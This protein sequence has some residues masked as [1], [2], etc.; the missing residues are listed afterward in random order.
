MSSK[1]G[2]S[3][4]V[5]LSVALLSGCSVFSENVVRPPEPEPLPAGR[6]P[7][8]PLAKSMISVPISVDLSAMLHHANDESVVPKKFD[9]WGAH[10]KS[11]KGMDFKYYAERDDFAINPSGAV[12]ATS[13]EGE[14]SLRDWW[15][16]MTAT[17]ASVAVSAG[18]RYKAE[19]HPSVH[20]AGLSV[21]C[22]EGSEWPRRA[23]L[24]GSVAM[25]IA[26]NYNVS[27]SVIGVAMNTIDP[28]LIRPAD[29]N[30]TQEVRQR[31]ADSV[32]VGLT[33]AVAPINAMTVRSQVEHVWNALRTPIKLDQDMWLQL[34]TDMVGQSGTLMGGPIVE[35]EIQIVANPVVVLGSEPAAVAATLPPLDTQPVA[36]GFRVAAD[37]SLDYAELSK[38]LASRLKGK[39]LQVK[40]DVISI[41]NAAISGHGGNKVL[42]R[43]DFNG[44]V[45]GHVYMIG[46]PGMNVLTQSV[47]IGDLYWDPATEKLLRDGASWLHNSS[48]RELV[49]EQTVFGV[50]SETDRIKGLLVAALNRPLS[51]TVSLR[52]TVASVQGINVFADVNSLHVQVMSEGTLG[53][54]GGGKN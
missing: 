37:V 26:P 39:R 3:A 48:F 23:T 47:F 9:H 32:R 27:A 14:R 15:K 33:R 6:P 2:R 17:G 51:P 43:I 49:G 35:G 50:T 42:L 12:Y 5:F 34:N 41:T 36:P 21:H 29:L 18:V 53:V 40:G 31:V 1:A 10:I 19:V 13:T 30:P 54:T 20:T 28:C 8:A 16:G 44:D 25:G 46:K 7:L 52:G 11:P 38:T 22:G 24:D 4:F 45:Y